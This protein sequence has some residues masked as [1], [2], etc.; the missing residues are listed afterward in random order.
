MTV[1]SAAQHRP[2][3]LAV[4]DYETNRVVIAA[5]LEPLGF[6]VV[7]A[8]TGREAVDLGCERAFALILMDVHLPDMSGGEAATLLRS[9][10]ANAATP[11]MFLSGD[12]VICEALISQGDAVLEKPYRCSQ[13]V[14]RVQQLLDGPAAAPR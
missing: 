9:R 14:S 10:P 3:I 13:L 8:A 2:S 6:E 7:T 5:L 4:D 12:D 1:S 11:V